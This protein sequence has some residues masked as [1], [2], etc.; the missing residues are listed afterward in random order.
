MHEKTRPFHISIAKLEIG[1]RGPQTQQYTAWK[2]SF[3]SRMAW[4]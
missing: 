1:L 3:A 4:T 2:S